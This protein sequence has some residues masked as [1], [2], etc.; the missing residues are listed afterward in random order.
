MVIP[1]RHRFP[2]NCVDMFPRCFVSMGELSLENE[3]QFRVDRAVV[4]IESISKAA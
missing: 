3:Y 4:S 1:K 2:V